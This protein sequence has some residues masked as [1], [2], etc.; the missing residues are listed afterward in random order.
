MT[1]SLH[2]F[3]CGLSP[4]YLIIWKIVRAASLTSLVQSL[5]FPHTVEL[6]FDK[7]KFDH[8]TLLPNILGQFHIASGRSLI[9]KVDRNRYPH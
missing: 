4:P 9:Y 8:V 2:L 5:Q 1:P 7:H 3:D 6:T